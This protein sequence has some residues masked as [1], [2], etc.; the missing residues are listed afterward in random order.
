MNDYRRRF[1]FDVKTTAPTRSRLGFTLIELILVLSMVG[2]LLGGTISL[3]SLAQK[4]NQRGQRNFL[5]RQEI[6]RFADDVRRDMHAAEKAELAA[7]ELVLT[8]ASPPSEI[9]YRVA[10]GSLVR[11]VTNSEDGTQR[12]QD[13]YVLA[14]DEKI[15]M[16]W[17]EEGAKVRWT[18]TSPNRPLRPVRIIAARRS[19]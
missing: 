15:A 11:L 10:D 19:L 17:V 2:S 12:S 5:D 3:L 4:S 14:S 6:R 13:R 18:I 16:S 1:T 7:A 9:T 8:I